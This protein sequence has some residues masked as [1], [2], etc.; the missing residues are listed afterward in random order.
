MNEDNR[1]SSNC[2]RELARCYVPIQV[3]NT[4]YDSRE[5]LRRG[6]LFPELLR[7][8]VPC[9]PRERRGNYYG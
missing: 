8:Y 6:T 5:A 9:D 7:P 1:N 3:M 2:G 4:V